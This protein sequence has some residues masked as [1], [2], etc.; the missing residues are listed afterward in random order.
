MATEAFNEAKQRIQRLPKDGVKDPKR[1]LSAMLDNLPPSGRAAIANETIAFASD[2]E[3]KQTSEYYVHNVFKPNELFFHFELKS[4]GGATPTS[5]PST[6]EELEVQADELSGSLG[7]YA[8]SKSLERIC[9]PRDNFK[10]VVTQL[11]SQR[12]PQYLRPANSIPA[13]TQT[14]HIVPLAL[15]QH[16]SSDQGIL[17][18]SRTTWSTLYRLFPGLESRMIGSNLL[19]DINNPRNLFTVVETVHST[20]GRFDLALEPIAGQSNLYN[21]I[22]WQDGAVGHILPLLPNNRIARL[23]NHGDPSVPLP[24][25]YFFEVHLVIS[26]ILHASGLARLLTELLEDYCEF[27]SLASDGSTNIPYSTE[28]A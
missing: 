15:A 18:A 1:V 26:R 16:G 10:R 2:D 12:M 14:C 9:F 13:P 6:Y 28:G 24:D 8:S 22:V 21:I 4:A 20:F 7:S 25:P 27:H 17:Q 23:S 5:T 19:T 11:M 3:L